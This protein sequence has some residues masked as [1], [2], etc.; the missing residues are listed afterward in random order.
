MLGEPSNGS[1]FSFFFS[2][3]F[4]PTSRA[5]RVLSAPPLAPSKVTTAA[6]AFAVAK[7]AHPSSVLA[8]SKITA[9]ALAFAV[10]ITVAVAG[11]YPF[12]SRCT[13]EGAALYRGVEDHG[14]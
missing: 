5:H 14:G 10:P 12:S 3:L 4:A 13:R 11:T 6:L 9:A 2:F 8:A 1:L 7:A